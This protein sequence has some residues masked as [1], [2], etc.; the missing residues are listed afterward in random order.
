METET[1]INAMEKSWYLMY[2]EP[3]RE[4]QYIAFRQRIIKLTHD[5]C[6]CLNCVMHDFYKYRDR[7]MKELEAIDATTDAG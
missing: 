6:H 5:R 3:C 2:F 4:R 7:K 1:L